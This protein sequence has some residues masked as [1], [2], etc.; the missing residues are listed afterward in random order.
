[1]LKQYIKCKIE[2]RIIPL[3]LTFYSGFASFTAGKQ[4]A[5]LRG[6]KQ[7]MRGDRD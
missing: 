7:Q 2:V 1:M 6:D 5:E 4:K 3:G